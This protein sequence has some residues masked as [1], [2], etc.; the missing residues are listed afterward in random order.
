[1]DQRTN[2]GKEVWILKET[3]LKRKGGANMIKGQ[4]DSPAEE[5]PQS[6]RASKILRGGGY[7]LGKVRQRKTRR[8]PWAALPNKGKALTGNF[9]WGKLARK[10]PDYCKGIPNDRSPKRR[11][12]KIPSRRGRARQAVQASIS[13]TPGEVATGQT[14]GPSRRGK[15]EG[16]PGNRLP[17]RGAADATRRG[18]DEK[19]PPNRTATFQRKWAR[20]RMPRK[21]C[22]TEGTSGARSSK[23]KI[24]KEKREGEIVK[25]HVKKH[26]AG[27]FADK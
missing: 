8:S 4:K 6:P 20:Q 12:W 14:G 19:K 22:S 17:G 5:K 2:Q 10:E 16:K 26:C 15:G 27:A 21:L 25:W 9:Q 1:V 13:T 3:M 23:K 7:P 18:Y 24:N 11:V